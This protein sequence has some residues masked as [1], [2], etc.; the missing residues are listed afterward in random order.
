ME[1]SKIF[2]QQEPTLHSTGSASLV[3]GL[4]AADRNFSPI[5]ILFGI[6]LLTLDSF[7]GE[8]FDFKDEG[9][10]GWNGAHALLAVTQL[11]RNEKLPL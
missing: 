3:F 6:L 5:L 11:R 8:Q 4:S 2:A 10:A 9:A 1:E 7:D